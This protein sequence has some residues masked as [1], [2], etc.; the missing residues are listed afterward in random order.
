[1]RL[2]PVGLP[3]LPG[4]QT[5]WEL[6]PLLEKLETPAALIQCSEAT[7][8][9]ARR[10]ELEALAATVVEGDG[11][12][13]ESR[14]GPERTPLIFPDQPLASALPHFRRWPVLPVSNR[15]MRG[16]L[17]GVLTLEDVLERY[18]AG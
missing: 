7:W 13:L 18:Q 3:I 2:K 4:S 6:K 12:T 1:M 15:A 11:A 9:A 10:S 8:Y 16:A 5:V 14:L 17:E